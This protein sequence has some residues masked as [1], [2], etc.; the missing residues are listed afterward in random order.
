MGPLRRRLAEH[1]RLLASLRRAGVA[2]AACIWLP[3]ASAAATEAISGLQPATPQ[4]QA[5]SLMPGLAVEYLPGFIRHVDRLEEAGPGEPGPP[6]EML[7]WNSQQGEVLT[8]GRTDGIGARITGFIRFPAPGG[9][10]LTIQSNDGVR[11]RISE[12][13]V[14]EDPEVH[15]DRYSPDVLVNIETAGW[16]PLHVLYFERKNTSTLELYWQPP[17]ADRFD[18]VPASAFAHRKP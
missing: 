8:S 5:D 11:L 9:Y 3:L 14:I 6:L 7:D 10:L 4:P 18:Y 17:G 2:L 12:R 1:D 13:V 15:T 16:Y